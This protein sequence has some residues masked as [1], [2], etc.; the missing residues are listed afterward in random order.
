M[1]I[2]FGV[3][4]FG[5][6]GGAIVRG[7]VGKGVIA[8][9]DINVFD[10]KEEKNQ[11]A[12]EFGLNVL[13]DD[14]AVAAQSDVILLAVKPQQMLEA[15]AMTGKALEGKALFSIVAGVTVERLRKAIDAQPRILRIM[16]N[17]PAL[18][19]EGAFALCKENDL[20]D[21][22]KAF[23]KTLFESI[24]IVEWV[25]EYDIDAVCGLSGGGPAY[26]A[27]FIEAL[28]DGG[29]KQGLTRDVAY[30]LAAQ[31]VLGT[32]KMILETGIHP[33]ALKDMV[34][35]PAGTTIEG[36][37]VLEDFGFRAGV[38]KCV[39]AATDRSREL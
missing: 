4:G 16:P 5:N 34:T 1:S 20:T 12:R 25:K 13:Q 33:G 9:E 6:M 37:E 39:V 24:G 11:E 30:K 3:I 7:A 18:V 15:A 38:M 10:I 31:T 23:A 8:K 27:M 22:E 21:E 35:S 19:Y 28:A 36:V 29:V 17:T 2:K 32:A 26:A 14:E